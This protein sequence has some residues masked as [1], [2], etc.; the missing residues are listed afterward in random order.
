[1]KKV[2]KGF[3]EF[4]ALGMIIMG[5]LMA[6]GIMPTKTQSGQETNSLFPPAIAI[7]I[8][9]MCI[10]VK[11]FFIPRKKKKATN[12]ETRKQLAEDNVN[13]LEVL[14]AEKGLMNIS[15]TANIAVNQK[16]YID[17]VNK[18]WAVVQTGI[19]NTVLRHYVFPYNKLI[20]Y[21]VN[22]TKE[23]TIHGR[24]GSAIV[25]GATFGVIG[26]IAGSSRKKKV[27]ERITNIQIDIVVSDLTTP[28]IQICGADSLTV[29][30]ITGLLEYI[31]ANK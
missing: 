20:S 5:L 23:T 24:T 21:S 14:L 25:G 10:W 26:A 7:S 1:M 8:M 12:K 15:K 2:G 13:H 27:S 31:I 19:D 6:S 3:L 29:N 11:F 18:T 16:L 4:I 30:T 9:F 17:D 22:H 28:S